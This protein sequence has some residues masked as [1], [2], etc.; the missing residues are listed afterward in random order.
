MPDPI[1]TCEL[2][3]IPGL[4]RRWE[5]SQLLVPG[6]DYHLEDAGT[7]ADGSALV[8]VYRSIRREAD[9]AD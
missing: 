9:D 3:R 8:A 7:T 4:F 2:R 1:E 5:L 6:E